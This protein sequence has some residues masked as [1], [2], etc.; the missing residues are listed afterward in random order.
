MPDESQ[1]K[2]ALNIK[3]ST[4]NMIQYKKVGCM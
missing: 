1:N 4:E 2:T 3:Y